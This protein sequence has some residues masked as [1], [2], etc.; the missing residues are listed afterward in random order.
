MFMRWMSLH[1]DK[2]WIGCLMQPVMLVQAQV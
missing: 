2:G 1:Y